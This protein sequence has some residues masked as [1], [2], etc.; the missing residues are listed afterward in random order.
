MIKND[1]ILQKKWSEK[2][3]LY[4]KK[5]RWKNFTQTNS[6][7]QKVRVDEKNIK[8]FPTVSMMLIFIELAQFYETEFLTKQTHD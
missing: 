4:E 2:I 3:S 7:W 8:K 1:C 5:L 6:I